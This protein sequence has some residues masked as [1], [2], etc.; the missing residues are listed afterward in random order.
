MRK[1]SQSTHRFLPN[2]V[3]SPFIYAHFTV[4]LT[5]I[6]MVTLY[7]FPALDP[8]FH[9]SLVYHHISGALKI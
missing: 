5:L 3:R 1:C 2:L 4:Y 7:L 8:K 6:L 9:G